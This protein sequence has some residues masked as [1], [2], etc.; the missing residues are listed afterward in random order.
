MLLSTNRPSAPQLIRA[1]VFSVLL[2]VSTQMGIEILCS[3]I[4]STVTCDI[5]RSSIVIDS[6]AMGSSSTDMSPTVKNP[7]LLQGQVIIHFICL[8]TCLSLGL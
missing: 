5:S 1:V 2:S 4:E 3:D 7:L 8:W 6:V